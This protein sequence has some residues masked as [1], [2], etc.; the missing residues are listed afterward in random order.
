VQNLRA[1]PLLA[2]D[3]REQRKLQRNLPGVVANVYRTKNERRQLS[4]EQLRQGCA[5][6]R[7]YCQRWDSL[8]IGQDSLLTMILAANGTHPERKRVVYPAAIRWELV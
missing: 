7:L 5:K 8:R 3:V 1:N 6:F 4:E 2:G